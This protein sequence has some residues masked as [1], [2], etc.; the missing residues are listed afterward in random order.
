MNET[1]EAMHR[2][3]DSMENLNLYLKQIS[4]LMMD[5]AA[6]MKSL[7]RATEQLNQRVVELEARQGLSDRQ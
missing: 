5:L 1:A 7:G 6:Q 2:H 4:V 3:A